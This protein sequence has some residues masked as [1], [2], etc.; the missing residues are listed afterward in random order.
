MSIIHA[1]ISYLKTFML[2]NAYPEQIFDKIVYN[3][4][5]LFHQSKPKVPTVPKKT[6]Q[7]ILPYLGTLSSRIEKNLKKS[8]G[9]Y[10]YGCRLIV[11]SRATT[12]LSSLFS[13]KDKIPMYLVSGV[14]YKFKCGGCNSTYIGKTKRHTKNRFCEHAGTSPLTGK[15]LKLVG[16]TSTAVRKHGQKCKCDVN[17]DNFE[18]LSKDS[19][20]LQLLIKKPCLNVQ[21]T[22]IP[23][24]LS[25]SFFCCCC[26]FHTFFFYLSHF[27]FS[28]FLSPPCPLV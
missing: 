18:I 15:I 4:L 3:F 2:K 24:A 10:L 16:Q 11:I 13:F 27:P 5:T 8:I 19:N 14:I 26:S 22:S 7:I 20:N 17:F 6:I 23:L 12:R 25:I 9:K 21:N 1:E 28:L